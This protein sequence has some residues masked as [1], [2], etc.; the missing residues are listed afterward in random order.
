MTDF[1]PGPWYWDEEN[2]WLVADDPLDK[3][4][5]TIIL[6]PDRDRAKIVIEANDPDA[7]LIAAAPE[8]YEASRSLALSLPDSE[9]DL[10]REVWGNTNVAVVIHWRDKVLSALALVD[11]ETI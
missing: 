4:Y 2:G 1:T 5:G 8:L 9:M 6:A 7:R 11:K 3:L 10:A